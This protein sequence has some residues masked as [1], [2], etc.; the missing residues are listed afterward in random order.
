MKRTEQRCMKATWIAGVVLAALIPAGS[1]SAEVIDRGM[2]VVLG[3]PI[4]LSD[5]NAAMLFGLVQPQ[6]NVAD[7]IGSALDRLIERQLMLAEVDR[8]QPPEPAAQEIDTR[9]TEI[10]RRFGTPEKLDMALAGTGT[11]RDRLRQYIRDDLRITTYLNQRFGASAEPSDEDVRTYY[12]EHQS[13]FTS[14][15]RP[16]P[17]EAAANVIRLRL[18]QE[19]RQSLINEWLATL[20][21]RADVRVLYTPTK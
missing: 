19:R 18:G 21:R 14:G 15:G 4:L 3:Q 9:V 6:P 7:P 5:V 2:A 12:R 16:M 1:I 17:F 8:Y 10:E 20:R 11:T 13:E